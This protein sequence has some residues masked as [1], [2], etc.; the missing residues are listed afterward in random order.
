MP[1]LK[2]DITERQRDLIDVLVSS[3]RYRGAD[4]VLRDGL[5]LIER[6]EAETTGKLEA[7]RAAASAGAAAIDRGEFQLFETP[8]DMKAYLQVLAAPLYEEAGE[9]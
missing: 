4:D 3:G 1:N 8:S 6:R 7:L 5:C 2:I 9:S